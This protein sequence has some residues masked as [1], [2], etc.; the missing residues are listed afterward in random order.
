MEPREGNYQVTPEMAKF[1][2]T[3]YNYEHQ[4]AIRKWHVQN[5]ASEI[6]F[7][8]F[9]PKTQINFCYDGDHYYLTNGQHTLSAIIIAEKPILLNIIIIAVQ[10]LSEIAD[11]YGRT[12]NG[13]GRTIGDAL[14]AHGTANNLMVSPSILNLITA[15]AF[16]YE[17]MLTGY[18]RN[19][20]NVT[21]ERKLEI[22]NK[23]GYLLKEFI[24]DCNIKTGR[25]F[26]NRRAS[27]A[28]GVF[29]YA[30][31]KN[32]CIKFIKKTYS[33]DGLKKG[34]PCKA[35]IEFLKVSATSNA[36]SNSKRPVLTVPEHIF[37]KNFALAWN[38]FYK[39]KSLTFLRPNYESKEVYFE[40]CGIAKV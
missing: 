17:S 37:V 9:L 27:I 15:G 20:K 7:G 25:G 16:Y 6:T 2:I 31:R 19:R 14:K 18:L 26:A 23:Y 24:E 13:V 8:R 33:D 12:D 4:R 3:N 34:D 1:W 28:S 29:I 38:A 5:L 40:G 30:H 21:T 11:I 36:A 22:I 39:R 10:N 32:E 35:L